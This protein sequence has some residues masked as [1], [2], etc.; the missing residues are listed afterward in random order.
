MKSHIFKKT[1]RSF[2]FREEIANILENIVKIELGTRLGIRLGTNWA[3]IL[4]DGRQV[5]SML[6]FAVPTGSG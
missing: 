5:K 4:P 3:I 1:K 2:F 6:F